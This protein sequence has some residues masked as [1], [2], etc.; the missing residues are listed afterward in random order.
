M[1]KAELFRNL[2]SILLALAI[3]FLYLRLL[4][5]SRKNPAYRDRWLERLGLSHSKIQPGGIW[6][7]AVSVGEALAAIPIIRA[8]KKA[9]PTL[10][11]TVTTTTP[12]GAARIQQM[13]GNI[14]TH[15]YFP[16]DLPWTMA[17]F[18]NHVHPKLCLIMETELWPNFLWGLKTQKIPTF[19][20]NGRLSLH[21]MQGYQRMQKVTQL[22]MNCITAVAAQS[23]MDGDRFLSLGL[24]PS[25]LIITGNVKFDISVPEGIENDAL[26]LKQQWGCERPVWIAASTHQGEE[27]LILKAFQHLRLNFPTA[28]LILVPR[29]IERT[30]EIKELIQQYSFNYVLR[31]TAEPCHTDTAVLLA[32]TMGEMPLLYACS[33]VAF[34]GGSFVPIGGHNTLEPAFARVPVVVGPHVENFIDIT[35][36][37]LKAGALIQVQNSEKLID[38][39]SYWLGDEHAR[40]LAGQQGRKVV[41]EN[42]GAVD[43]IIQMASYYLN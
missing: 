10:P 1:R 25:Q 15:H 11:I 33:D 26:K 20:V 22:M 24:N 41:D 27:E 13:V 17:L 18:I 4:W 32:N 7:H 12:T 29:H 30:E 23:K 37:L 5:R 34:V 19:I 39:L 31:S 16:F 40:A 14:V 9:F 2:Y 3:P 36:Y 8:L 6:L 35:N 28:F 38:V 21:S 43:K 42:R